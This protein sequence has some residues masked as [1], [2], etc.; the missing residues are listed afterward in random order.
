MLT[1]AAGF[2]STP[3][4]FTSLGGNTSHWRTTGAT[5]IYNATPTGFRVHVRWADG[6]TLTPANANSLQWRSERNLR[7]MYVA[8]VDHKVVGCLVRRNLG[9]RADGSWTLLDSR[10]GHFRRLYPL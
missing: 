7:K 6:S 10:A 9:T 8:G 4:S 5:S 3:M 2:G 1:P